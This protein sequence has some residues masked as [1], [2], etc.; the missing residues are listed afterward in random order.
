MAAQFRTHSC[1]WYGDG[2]CTAAGL[3]GRRRYTRHCPSTHKTRQQ[4]CLCTSSV[5]AHCS[6][7]IQF[8]L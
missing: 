2:T 8:T 6:V 7:C 5:S 3:Q 4:S 1:G